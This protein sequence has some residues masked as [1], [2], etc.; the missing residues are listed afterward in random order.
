MKKTVQRSIIL[1]VFAI[2]VPICVH[3]SPSWDLGSS[4]GDVEGKEWIL[5]E[6]GS[7]GENILWDRLKLEA[8][9]F[10][11]IY[12]VQF[13]EGQLSGMG[14]PNRYFGPY[15]VGDNRA[16]SIGNLA[17]TMMMAFREPEGLRERE[18]FD[19]LS[20]TTRWDLRG[21]RRELYSS[22]SDG[23]EIVMVFGLNQ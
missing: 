2:M 4:F 13:L 12:T 5:L 19:L 1:I 22:G 16:L 11:G 9:G 8:E 20:K 17:S 7:P 21:G 15:T 10:G 6:L 3:A 14:A 23:V 18:Y